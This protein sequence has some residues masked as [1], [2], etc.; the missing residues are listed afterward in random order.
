MR[1]AKT[2]SYT[3][4]W[5]RA[6]CHV[7]DCP[8]CGLLIMVPVPM[9]LNISQQQPVPTGT[10][11][12]REASSAAP[13]SLI[14]SELVA[15]MIECVERYSLNVILD[16]MCLSWTCFLDLRAVAVLHIE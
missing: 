9:R 1:A 5:V 15:E 8:G 14:A 7:S 13:R 11:P 12:C 16:C 10:N 3:H 6:C 2:A 4:V